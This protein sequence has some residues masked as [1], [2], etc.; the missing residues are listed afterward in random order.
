VLGALLSDGALER[1]RLRIAAVAEQ[2]IRDARAAP[3]GTPRERRIFDVPVQRVPELPRPA[4]PVCELAPLS[5]PFSRETKLTIVCMGEGVRI[6]LAG[7]PEHGV[8]RLLRSEEQRAV[9]AYTA[10]PGYVGPDRIPLTAGSIQSPLLVD[11]QPFKLRALGDSVTAGFGFLQNGTPVRERAR[12]H[13][14]GAVREL[15]RQRLDADGLGDRLP[16]PDAAGDRGRPA[17]PG[18]TWPSRR[19]RFTASTNSR[20]CSAS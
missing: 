2:I 4:P 3:A 7:S 16:K 13:R 5:A 10:S 15:G 18:T 20:S 17:Q 1:G 8:A 19:R 14:A 9:F 11:V 6:R 12:A